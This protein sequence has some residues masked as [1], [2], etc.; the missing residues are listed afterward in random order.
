MKK[1]ISK[2]DFKNK[3]IDNVECSYGNV[4]D[5]QLSMVRNIFCVNVV[6]NDDESISTEV[7]KPKEGTI[8]EETG[9][10]QQEQMRNLCKVEEQE[11]EVREDP[12][13]E[14]QQLEVLKGEVDS[15]EVKE[16]EEQEP[17]MT[18]EKLKEILFE[19]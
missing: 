9:I 19:K 13:E 18:I 17:K 15:K 10:S 5:M 8:D 3:T 14:V 6:H 4:K 16:E 2:I 12:R 11:E 1:N 7:K